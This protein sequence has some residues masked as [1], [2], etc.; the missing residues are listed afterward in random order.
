MPACHC[1]ARA[2][3]GGDTGEGEQRFFH[4]PYPAPSRGRNYYSNP[5]AR[6][7]ASSSRVAT[8]N[9]QVIKSLRDFIE[10]GFA[11]LKKEVPI[12]SSYSNLG[13]VLIHS[14]LVGLR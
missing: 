2:G 1:E 5:V 8:G 11:A 7:S 9:Y 3:R 14:L 4:P 12:Q 10:R 13:H 6:L